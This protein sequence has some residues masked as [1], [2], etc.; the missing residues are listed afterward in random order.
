MSLVELTTLLEGAELLRSLL[1]ARVPLLS[2]RRTCHLDFL[3]IPRSGVSSERARNVVIQ[4]TSSPCRLG[5]LRD[6]LRL[7]VLG[8]LYCLLLGKLDTETAVRILRFT[9]LS[10]PFPDFDPVA[11]L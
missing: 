8:L 7:H 9:A 4:R 6:G 10:S 5:R 11:I 3:W 1:A 2:R